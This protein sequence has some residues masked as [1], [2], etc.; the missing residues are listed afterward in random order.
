MERMGLVTREWTT[1]GLREVKHDGRG[2]GSRSNRGRVSCVLPLPALRHLGM[3][4]GG[5]NLG[6]GK[7]RKVAGE[8]L[9]EGVLAGS[10][11]SIAR[12]A[13]W[14]LMAQQCGFFQNCL[15]PE[16]CAQ[17]SA[18]GVGVALGGVVSAAV[19]S[20]KIQI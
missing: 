17:G 19:I 15:A 7:D 9:K 13:Q 11:N 1:S 5:A 2:S 6:K 18:S 3:V 12:R 8:S 10:A 14:L 20:V 16:S 4:G